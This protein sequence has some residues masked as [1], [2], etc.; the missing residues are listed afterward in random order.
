MAAALKELDDD[1]I[2]GFLS[3][4]GC[5]WIKFTTN[6]PYASHMGGVWERLIRTVRAVLNALLVNHGT[7]LDDESLQT[8]LTEA[9][10]VVNSRPLTVYNLT[11]PGTLEPITPNHLLTGKSEIVVQPPDQI[12]IR[13]RDGAEYN[14]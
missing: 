4:K 8:L 10:S 12:C 3:N 6:V 1:A 7:Q 11:E 14:I 13:A 5:D 2:K 9:E